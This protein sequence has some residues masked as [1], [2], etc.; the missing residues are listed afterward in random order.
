[1]AFLTEGGANRLITTATNLH[2][3]LHQD[4]YGDDSPWDSEVFDFFRQDAQ[5][6]AM[7]RDAR[8][9]IKGGAF[10]FDDGNAAGGYLPEALTMYDPEIVEEEYEEAMYAD[11]GFLNIR[12]VNRPGVRTIKVQ[13]VNRVGRFKATADRAT[14]TEALDAGMQDTDYPT[15][16]IGAHIEY[17]SRELDAMAEAQRSEN[18]FGFLNMMQYKVKVVESAYREELNRINSTGIPSLGIYGMHTFY[19][20]P[21]IS[22]VL[23][24]SETST[25]EE[26]VSVF[27]RAI[28][29]FL[30][31][32]GEKYRPDMVM[33][34]SD[35]QETMS[36][37]QMGTSGAVSVL[38]WLLKTKNLRG[39]VYTTPQMRTEGASGPF[40]QFIRKSNA[41]QAIVTKGL[42][43]RAMPYQ[44]GG[45]TRV[46]YEA[47][48]AGFIS[49]KP[50][51]HLL[52]DNVGL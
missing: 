48:M 7:L 15:E 51:E 10:R 28:R 33:M 24:L 13:S 11:P 29:Q 37:R 32:T 50:F 9:Q 22:S 44:A 8:N 17:T 1:M 36:S 4:A 23:T 12:N 41:S 30:I 31:N 25:P 35:L 16:Y 14:Q 6:A 19:G 38:D 42:T 20:L 52:V 5:A 49:K 21:R 2:A 47:A 46:D 26:F 27:D 43:Q 39:G 34:T 45:V 40:L 18:V 3:A